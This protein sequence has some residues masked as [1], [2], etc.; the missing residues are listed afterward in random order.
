MNA[1]SRQTWTT[2]RPKTHLEHTA[3]PDTRRMTG[4]AG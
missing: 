3:R 2:R 4:T 1:R